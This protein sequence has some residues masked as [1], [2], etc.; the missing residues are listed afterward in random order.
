[1]SSTMGI[2]LFIIQEWCWGMW[3]TQPELGYYIKK[4]MAQDAIK[5]IRK[6]YK[7]AGFRIKEFNII[8]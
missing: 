1:M 3:E 6:E 4:W 7:C 2:N 5:K 8:N